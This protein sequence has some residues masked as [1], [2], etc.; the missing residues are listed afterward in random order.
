MHIL[1]VD[2]HD[3]FRQGLVELLQNRMQDVTISEAD[4]VKSACEIIKH[5]HQSF[6]L[7]L[8]DHELPDGKG[9]NLLAEMRPA[10]PDLSMVILSAGEDPELMQRALQLGSLGYLPKN[11][12]TP[13]LLSGIE[14]ILS[15]GIYIPP[16]LLSYVPENIPRVMLYKTATMMEQKG[17]LTQRQLEVLSLLQAGLSNKVIA[18]KLAI[19][20]ATV[21]AHVTTILRSYG[22][23][24][25]T[26]LRFSE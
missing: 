5:H 18:R 24:S 16:G 10:Y 14:L 17:R 19:S 6:D 15:G 3:L 21:K 23:S 11:T 1:I 7:V 8:L 13:V 26:Q 4:S 22:V 9:L 25:R 20:E 12:P 2:D